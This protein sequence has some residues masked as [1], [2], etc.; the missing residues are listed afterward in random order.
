MTAFRLLLI[1]LL[2]TIIGYTA[3][4]VAEHGFTLIPVFF[5]DIA[6]FGWPGQ[7]NVDFATFLVLSALWV[8]WRHQFS[9]IGLILAVPAA[10]GGMLFLATY[11]LIASYAANGD[12]RVLL[13]GQGRATP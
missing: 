7:F 5:G 9:A 6:A 2:L 4:V 13:L 3:I 12:A 10:F 8:A 1:A 11:L